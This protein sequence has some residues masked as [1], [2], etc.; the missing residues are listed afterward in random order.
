MTNDNVTFVNI[1]STELE[2]ASVEE[3]VDT[4]NENPLLKAL[5]M[6]SLILFKFF[7]RNC[8]V[9]GFFESLDR[10]YRIP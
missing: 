5:S 7:D 10:E 9:T 2:F 1:T 4:L 3:F 6:Y 8:F